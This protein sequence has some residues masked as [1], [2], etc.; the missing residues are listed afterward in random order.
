MTGDIRDILAKSDAARSLRLEKR[1]AESFRTNHWPASRGVYYQDAETG[2]QREIDVYSRHLLDS[3]RKYE[4]IGAPIINMEIF[5]ECKSLHNSNIILSPDDIGEKSRISVS[6]YW[7]GREGELA[8]VV[9]RLSNEYRLSKHRDIRTLYDHVVG[10]AYPDDGRALL[11][12]S[13]VTAPPVEVVAT[14]FRETKGGRESAEQGKISPAWGAVRA[15][16]SAVDGGLARARILS[17]DY[18][19]ASLPPFT[20]ESERVDQTSFFLDAELTRSTYLH[21]F[22]VLGAKLWVLRDA[23]VSE[24][25]SARIIVSGIESGDR[26]VDIVN[27]DHLDQYMSDMTSHFEA[28]SKS[29]IERLWDHIEEVGWFPGADS[30][31]LRAALGILEETDKSSS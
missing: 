13:H 21:P 25:K 15:C 8:G 29:H 23:E 20:R 3:P 10:R 27:E 12:P 2:K 16:L 22:V 4:G 28:A 7:V 30:I 9:D 19:H 6:N 14:A 17:L 26:Y 1:V 31:N 11:A 5:C 18:V 24:V